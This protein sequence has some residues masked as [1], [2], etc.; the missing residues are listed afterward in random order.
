M[1]SS[2]FPNNQPQKPANKINQALQMIQGIK[3]PQAM[4]QNLMQQNPQFKEFVT[5]NQGK[6]PD[7][8]AKENGLDLSSI[9][10]LLGL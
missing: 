6:S 3:N 7:Q 9:K 1:A 2:L 10:G 5:Q 4:A 8:I